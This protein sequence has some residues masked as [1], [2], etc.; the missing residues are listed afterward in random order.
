MVE[1]GVDNATRGGGP[2]P[3]AV[4]IFKITSMHLSISS[5]K[6]RSSRI[7]TSWSHHLMPRVDK[8]S[9]NCGTDEAGGAGDKNTHINALPSGRNPPPP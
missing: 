6:R 9:D 1:A 2:T 5:R 7:R 4:R 8:L 3:Q